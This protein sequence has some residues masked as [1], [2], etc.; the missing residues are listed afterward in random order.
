MYLIGGVE[1]DAEVP[2]VKKVNLFDGRIFQVSPMTRPRIYASVVA[3]GSSIRIFGGLHN[4][5]VLRSCEAYDVT[6]DR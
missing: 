6:R 3:N 1:R 5:K 4:M 2:T